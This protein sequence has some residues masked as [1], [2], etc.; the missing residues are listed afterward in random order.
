MNE[1][2]VAATGVAPTPRLQSVFEALDRSGLRWSLLRPP[3]TLGAAEGDVDLL[4]EA[5]RLDDARRVLVDAGF[6]P[7]R[8]PGRDLHA[9]DHDA[10]AGRFVWLHV[11]TEV[12]IGAARV[13]AGAVLD[14]VVA[15]PLPRPSDPWLLWI[16][17]L[18]A[19][20]DKGHIPERH[21]PTVQRLA[22]AGLEAPQ[23]LRDEA[24]RAG[25]DAE[26]ALRHGAA[27]DWQALCAM[28]PSGRARPRRPAARA[29]VAGLTDRVRATWAQPGIG[30][31][32]IGPD[33]A[34]KTTLIN[35]L[36]ETIPLPVRVLYMG[37]TGGRLPKA[38]ALRV[39]GLVL[40]ARLALIWTRYLVATYHRA[41]GR[42]VLFDRYPLDAAVPSGMSLSRLATTS[43]RVQGRA[44]PAPDLVLLLDAPGA[45]MHER[46]GEYEP[47]RLEEWR[48]AY[49]RLR[50]RVAHIEVLD[51]SQPA[52]AVLADAQASIW[53]RYRDRWRS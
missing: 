42:I 35:G 50:E 14:D 9:L 8:M 15:D 28:R 19:V 2:P 17:L 27:G 34:G 6:V 25:L 44:V 53:R 39:P 24:E 1:A 51:A 47:E 45:L 16:L 32:I 33:G 10:A 26:R 30:V 41:R 4:V 48:L 11:Q 3:E 37:L 5:S 40:A 18:R 13:S 46:K 31:A 38:D 12:A 36:L 29:R 43:R 49:L 21:R 7:L 23:L 22:R 20:L 52:E